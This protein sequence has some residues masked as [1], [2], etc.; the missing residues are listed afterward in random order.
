MFSLTIC[1]WCLHSQPQ[2]QPFPFLSH[3]FRFYFS[4]SNIFLPQLCFYFV[5]VS[6]PFAMCLHFSHFIYIH[7]T[8][9]E[10]VWVSVSF[11]FYFVK[12]DTKMLVVDRWRFK[13]ETVFPL[14]LL[15]V[16]WMKRKWLYFVREKKSSLFIQDIE[17][18]WH[19]LFVEIALT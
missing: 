4:F 16:Y 17:W 7:R 14:F 19:V 15:A 8:E 12:N 13:S 10:C 6:L 1:M 18:M 3:P 2:S 5:Y 11:F 9:C